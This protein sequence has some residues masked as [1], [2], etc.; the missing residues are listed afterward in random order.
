MLVDNAVNYRREI[1][2]LSLWAEN[3]YIQQ[4]QAYFD[5]ERPTL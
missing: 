3:D 4:T 5:I 1:F 2:L